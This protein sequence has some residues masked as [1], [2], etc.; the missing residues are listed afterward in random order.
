MTTHQYAIRMPNGKLYGS[1]SGYNVFG[2]PITAKAFVWDDPAAA[3]DQLAQ[4]RDAA[5]TLGVE[6]WLGVVVQR[7]CSEFTTADP[8]E[9]FAS[10][11]EKWA[12]E[13]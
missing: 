10:E 4:L 11:I 12:A 5:Q 9:E 7:I 8:V 2:Q 13:Q 1:K 3:A 6:D